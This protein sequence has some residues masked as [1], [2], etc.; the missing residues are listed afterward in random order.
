MTT[1]FDDLPE[2]TKNFLLALRPDEVK[3]L[4]DG[5]RLVGAISTVA[6]VARWFIIGLIGFFV[7][8]VMLWENA[9]KIFHFFR[10]P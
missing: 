6:K 10:P 2:P 8:A 7:G 3:M 4:H 1:K 5:I 9:I